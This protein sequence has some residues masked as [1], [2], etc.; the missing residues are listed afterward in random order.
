LSGLVIAARTNKRGLPIFAQGL[1]GAGIAI[2]YLS[3]YA[4]YNFYHL[5]PALAALAAMFVV[6][7]I[8]F[9]QALR[10]DSLVVSLLSLFGGFL[11]PLVESHLH[12]NA[13][14]LF[15][16]V[17]LL[18]AGALAIAGKKPKWFVLEPLTLLG[19][20]LS[21]LL[22]YD[23]SY[24]PSRWLSTVLLLTL[25]WSAFY[26]YDIY[27][28]GRAGT[29]SSHASGGPAEAVQRRWREVR[30][31]LAAINGIVYYIGLYTVIA[32]H[33]YSWVAPATG[34]V[35]AVYALTTVYAIRRS[36]VDAAA[37]ARQ[38]L[39][40]IVLAVLAPALAFHGFGITIAWTLEALALVGMGALW[41]RAFLWMPAIAVYVLAV[42]RLISLP[43]TY[44]YHSIARFL[45]VFNDRALTMLLLT[46][47]LAISAVL[48]QRVDDVRIPT[49]RQ[50]LIYTSA[51]L[52]FLFLT[53]ETNDLFRRLMAGTAGSASARLSYDR[54]LAIGLA[55]MVYALP[56]IWIG[57]KR[58]N[59]PMLRSGLAS[60]AAA[61]G[62]TA[63]VG[64]SFS[65]IRSFV[66]VLNL[67]FGLMALIIGALL[68]QYRWLATRAD[69]HPTRSYLGHA[70]QV[71]MV[72]MGF[73]LMTVEVNDFF[74]HRTVTHIVS[75]EALFVEFMILAGLWMVYSL[76]LTWTG[77]HR[78]ATA[79]L[80]CGILS[81][82]T[83]V[84][85]GMAEGVAFQPRSSFA[86]VLGLRMSIFLLLIT[87]IIA[88]LQ[89]IR[90]RDDMREWLTP[91]ISIFQA[92][93][94][95]L[96]FALISVET[97]DIFV[98]LIRPSL[99]AAIAKDADYLHN[100]EQLALS[101]AWLAYAIGIIVVGIWRQIRWLRLGAIVLFGFIILKIFAYDL[102]FLQA[103]LRSISFIVLGL[104]LLGVSYM[105][106]RYRSLLFE[107]TA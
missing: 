13:Y 46:A 32:Q 92:A 55:W 66:P 36:K 60:T 5:V 10:Y 65:P 70:M 88:E 63:T 16:Y 40:A 23:S 43:E 72:A 54:F 93:I 59:P 89:W 61:V 48:L 101:L 21:Y 44:R 42:L 106:Q 102:G 68:V 22:W 14:G 41:K 27:V 79:L 76:P 95:I 71:A 29:D 25:L 103:G 94:V 67:R 8:G 37:V 58:G 77:I 9:Q 31:G 53:V 75:G 105:Y 86:V 73:E 47:A 56:L 19:T 91:V 28:L 50:L 34:A 12:P 39:S 1:V 7:A 74:R 85:A 4:S 97:R 38:A 84:I 83:S 99:S 100:L 90:K 78:R 51:A 81:A 62:M 24:Q 26:V 18:A 87:G 69:E 30:H 35:A 49:V 3:V 20:Y 104:I 17:F 45:P 6:T 2:L 64:A 15:A 98:Y 82:A 96:G 57:L 52:F 11:T 80:A 33:H 107:V